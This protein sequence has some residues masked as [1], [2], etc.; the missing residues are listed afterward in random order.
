MRSECPLLVPRGTAKEGLFY[1]ASGDSQLAVWQHTPNAPTVQEKVILICP[2]IGHE[3]VHTYRT[4]RRLALELCAAGHIVFRFDYSGTGDSSGEEASADSLTKWVSDIREISNAITHNYPMLQQCWLG[5]RFGATLAALAS[6]GQQVSTLVLWEPVI[7]GRAY[8]RELEALAMLSAKPNETE[9]NYFEC[10]GYLYSKQTVSNIK[11]INLVEDLELD[12]GCDVH[13]L[14]CEQGPITEL[15]SGAIREQ[16]VALTACQIADCADMMAE[17]QKT[18]IPIQS[19]KYICSCLVSEVTIKLDEIG[20]LVS[21]KQVMSKEVNGRTIE[22]RPIFFGDDNALFGVFS[23]PVNS[24]KVSKKCVVLLNSGSV[25]HMGPGAI[26]NRIAD[27]L[28]ENGC[29]VLCLDLE[30]IG[31]SLIQ[32]SV[33]ENHPYQPRAV[34]NVKTVIDSLS[35][36]AGIETFTVAGIC[37]GAHAAFHVGLESN[38]KQLVEVVMI[39]PLTFYWHKGLSLDIPS[40]LNVF[41]T[42]AYYKQSLRSLD[43]WKKLLSAEA[44]LGSIVKFVLQRMHL[45]FVHLLRDV[46]SYVTQDKTLLSNDIETILHKGLFVRFVFAS[47]D[48]GQDIVNSEAKGT[49]KRGVRQEKISVDLIHGADHTFT[50]NESRE[51]L[52]ETLQKLLVS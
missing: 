36:S 2:P 52:L 44:Q 7:R 43:K 19:I 22:R 16:G 34:L 23:L 10:A 5:L 6:Q 4:L 11:K 1:L 50:S 3:H 14:V 17:P 27:L 24:G 39:N 49:V 21:A 28:S 42:Q 30:N 31:D 47:T 45:Y 20:A 29:A 37:S 40:T 13:Y 48:P 25:H 12:S 8:G 38:C 35:N 46:K 41:R 9:S 15:F 18:V 51:K 33:S 26:Y 32:N